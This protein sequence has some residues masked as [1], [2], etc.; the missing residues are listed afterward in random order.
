MPPAVAVNTDGRREVLGLEVGPSEAEPFW[1]KFLRSLTRRDLRGV[2]LVI[3]DAH[4]GL[5]TAASKVLSATWQRCRVH[6]MRNALAHVGAKQRQMVAAAIR[7]HRRMA[8]RTANDDEPFGGLADRLAAWSGSG[9]R[10]G[11]CWT[12]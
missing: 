12:C 11:R 4:E 3:S 9:T 8:R 10:D 1:T 7:N 5:K 2:K 6:F